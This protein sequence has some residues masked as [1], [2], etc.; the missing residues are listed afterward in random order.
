MDWHNTVSILHIKFRHKGTP[1]QPHYARNN[2]IYPHVLKRIIL[3]HN[4]VV[5]TVACRARQVQ[6]K[7]PS[8][9]LGAFRDDAETTHME[10]REG[11]LGEGARHPACLNFRLQV[12]VDDL[13]V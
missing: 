9:R 4:S 8:P 7:T 6:D 5:D 12:T 11:R 2:A 13:R 3:A 10:D 1:A